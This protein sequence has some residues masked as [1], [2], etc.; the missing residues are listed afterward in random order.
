MF[1][2]NFEKKGRE[3]GRGIKDT[4]REVEKYGYILRTEHRKNMIS[5]PFILIKC[6]K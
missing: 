3:E 4:E 6:K 2:K 5:V 1:C